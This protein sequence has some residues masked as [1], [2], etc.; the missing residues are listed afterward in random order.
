[1][2]AHIGGARGE[3]GELDVVIGNVSRRG[4]G[5]HIGQRGGEPVYGLVP[6]VERLL[7]RGSVKARPFLG[8]SPSQLGRDLAGLDPFGDLAGR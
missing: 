1:V 6:G 3:L 7:A 5:V 8:G 4:V 2:T